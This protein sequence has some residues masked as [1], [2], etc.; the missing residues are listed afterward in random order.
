MIAWFGDALFGSAHLDDALPGSAHPIGLSRSYTG[1]QIRC[2][3]CWVTLI[4]TSGYEAPCGPDGIYLPRHML[5][6]CRT[7]L[8]GNTD[9]ER[10][11]DLLFVFAFVIWYM[12]SAGQTAKDG[13]TIVSRFDRIP[14]RRCFSCPPAGSR[15]ASFF[16]KGSC[17]RRPGARTRF[18]WYRYFPGAPLRS[19]PLRFSTGSL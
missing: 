8:R 7:T 14:R 16:R 10:L 17:G 12:Q 13:V 2:R 19:A 15:A 5:L 9:V 1:R 3:F 6:L 11:S 18:R 4:K